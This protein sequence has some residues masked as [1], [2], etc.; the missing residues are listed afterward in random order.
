MRTALEGRLRRSEG[1]IRAALYCMD[2]LELVQII[3]QKSRH[4]VSVQM[5]FDESQVRS[6]SC[7]SQLVR[8]LELIEMGAA[9]YRLRV[10]PGF[11]VLHQKLLVIDGRWVFTGSLNPTNN[12]FSNND[13][14]LVE[15]DVPSLA[16]DALTHIDS[17]ITRAEPV[18][19]EFLYECIRAREEKK[20]SRSSSARR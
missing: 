9:L 12:G 13:E 15:I 6:P 18:T 1:S 19:N 20:R 5:V 17:L 11:A 10:G 14:N 16:V 2:D 7:S 8:M 3:S 4:G